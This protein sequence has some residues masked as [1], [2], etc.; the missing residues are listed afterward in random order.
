VAPNGSKYWRFKY[1]F[2]DKEKLLALGVYPEVTLASARAKRDEAR[3]LLS[4]DIDPGL[5]KQIK[6]RSKI[7]SAENSFE[8]IAREWFAKHSPRWVASHSEKIIRRFERDVFP[9]LGNRPIT[10]ITSPEL[11]AVLRRIESRGAIV[12]FNKN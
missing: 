6:K 7:L 9:W 2:G 3:K 8:A 11:L 1:R 10:A 12:R 4:N 5:D